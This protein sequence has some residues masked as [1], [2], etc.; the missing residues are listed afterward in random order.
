L[1][2]IKAGDNFIELGAGNGLILQE[3]AKRG[4]QAC[5]YEISLFPY[6]IGK[7]RNIFS[8][9]KFTL[10]YRNFWSINL[11]NANIVYF[12]LLPDVMPKISQKLKAECQPGTK[13]ISY[14]FAVPD[15]KLINIDKM[16]NRP[17]LYLYEI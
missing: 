11:K 8:Q 1:L 15:L 16:E 6:F 5:G 13:V 7:I 4:T 2:K 14:V 12:F 9:K 10:K 3:A 17:N